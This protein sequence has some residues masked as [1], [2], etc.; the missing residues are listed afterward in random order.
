[1]FT[2]K[3]HGTP[4]FYI[5]DKPVYTTF[6]R[7]PKLR[8]PPHR[9][10]KYLQ[11]DEFLETFNLS[12]SDARV[13]RE[14]I[15]KNVAPEGS[16][17]T[18]FYEVR[19][20]LNRRLFTTIDLRGTDKTI[21]W[22][23]PDDPKVW[24]TTQIIIGS[25]GVGKTYKL[26]KE[27]TESLQRRRKRKFVYL[28]PE[29]NEDTTLK[30]LVQSKRFRKHFEGID[31]GDDAFDDWKTSHEGAG[32]PEEWW[33]DEVLPALNQQPVGT[34]VALDD[35]PDSVLAPFIRPWL[36]KMLRTGRHKKIG[37]GSIQHN[38]RGGRW[39]SQSYSSVKWVNLFPRG[40]RQ[41]PDCRV[42]GRAS[43]SQPQEGKRLGGT[44][45]GNRA[46]DDDSPMVSSS[47]VW[48]QICGV[49]LK[50]SYIWVELPHHDH[51]PVVLATRPRRC[52][53]DRYKHARAALRLIWRY[54]A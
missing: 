45:R 40:G 38:V 15:Q 43:G 9:G 52:K 4:L 31:I 13:L 36:V 24:P 35:S 3:Q 46:M 14:A 33:K 21:S 34:F 23:F 6:E 54:F 27:I 22:R 51:F 30:K 53:R 20:A 12:K 17:K 10:G 8:I 7:D 44:V 49:C 32:T 16:L 42:S 1:M 47:L 5:D 39:T 29:L 28:S 25:S 19:R 41:R 26:V 48:S 50:M 11:S 18:K 37:V 2:Y